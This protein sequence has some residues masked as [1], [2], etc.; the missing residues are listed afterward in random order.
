MRHALLLLAA[1]SAALLAACGKSADDKRGGSPPAVVTT[2]VLAPSAWTDSIAA[3][4][5]ARARESVTI[6]AKL[7]DTVAKVDFD[8]G[9]TVRAG[10]VLVTLSGRAQQAELAAAEADYRQA[11]ALFE[12]QQD[13][14]KRQLIAASQFDTQR[15]LRDGARARVEQMRAQLADRVITAP[16]AGTLGLRQVSPGSLVS[17]GTV[18]TT[19]DD[20][21]RVQ[22]DFSLPES[23]LPLLAVGQAVQAR[24]DAYPGVDFPGRILSLDARV[25]PATR[26][27]QARAELDNPDARLRAGML[28]QV[29]VQQPVR[30]ALQVREL[31]IQQVGEQAYVFKVGNDDTVS[32][33]P[34]TLG[35]RRPGWVELRS[36]VQAGDR[37]VVEGIV[38]L[39]AG[40]KIVEAAPDAAPA[41]AGG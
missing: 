12:R 1:L 17:P 9:Q 15:A 37:I 14:V 29:A 5:S 16:F 19:L 35:A 8:S 23:Q 7:S 11:Q 36:G 4:G 34:V 6:T 32:Q 31:A 39:H 27:I 28:L 18:I 2:V 41:A 20:I 25:D 10:Q 40:S 33:V 30:Q 38:K 26:A 3:L 13:L 24:S 21:S 22:V